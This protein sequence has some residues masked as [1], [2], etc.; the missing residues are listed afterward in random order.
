M[1]AND[2][3][4]H[5]KEKFAQPEEI[6]EYARV[7]AQGLH[8]WE[9]KGVTQYFSPPQH[10]LD[11]GCGCGRE[12]IGLAQMGFTVTAI[13]LVPQMVELTKK[14]TQEKKLKL[15]AK[16]MNACRLEFPDKSFDG[17]FMMEQFL[18][19]IPGTENRKIALKEAW[20]VLKPGGILLMSVCSRNRDLPRQIYWV[21]SSFFKHG[22][23]Y[24]ALEKGDLWRK[25]V[26]SADSKGKIVV[27][28]FTIKEGKT[29]LKDS[30]FYVLDCRSISDY[31]QNLYPGM[32]GFSGENDYALLFAGRKP[33]NFSTNSATD[34]TSLDFSISNISKD[35]WDEFTKNEIHGHLLQSASWG[36]LEKKRGFDS[37]R[38]AAINNKDET[39][40][41]G[42]SLLAK[43][44]PGL[45]KYILYAPRG[46]VFNN[47]FNTKTKSAILTALI[48]KTKAL[49]LQKQAIFLKV[50]PAVSINDHLIHILLQAGLTPAPIQTV[51]FGTQ[52]K[53]TRRVSLVESEEKLF[54]QMHHK[55]RQYINKLQRDGIIIRQAAPNE[56]E[57]LLKYLV[58]W[59]VKGTKKTKEFYMELFKLF[60][61]NA[62][63]FV[64]ELPSSNSKEN[65]IIAMRILITWGEKAWEFY[66]VRNPAFPHIRASYLLVWEMIKTAKRLGCQWYDF[67]GIPENAN[68]KNRFHGIYKFKNGFGG[69]DI[70]FAGEFDLVFEPALYQWW[71]HGV[72]LLSAITNIKNQIFS[73]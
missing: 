17:I 9:M 54:S 43:K 20:R 52:P 72:T 61:S 70:E 48:N 1:P 30:G 10:I 53:F 38:L 59:Q 46:P 29:L 6:A 41:G 15:D 14:S 22:C 13:D 27:H 62:I 69:E 60:Q 35:R 57:Q 26:D 21:L 32:P 3:F 40:I 49:A 71:N 31:M 19:N 45:S 25:K 65:N 58:L 5:L 66:G 50:D 18:G 55:H 42:V 11:I 16:V 2:L 37:I 51:L 34:V 67:R 36:E 33:D 28:Y 8:P 73:N 63:L 44:I 47:S 64:A 23:K 68:P 7:V 12:G 39:I 24:P 56:L 4:E